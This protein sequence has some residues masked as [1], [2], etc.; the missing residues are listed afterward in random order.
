MSDSR[1]CEGC[2]YHSSITDECAE[3]PKCMRD[4]DKA[5]Y[6]SYIEGKKQCREE[7]ARE[8]ADKL[9]DK[10]KENYEHKDL[11][12]ECKKCMIWR[13]EEILETLAEWQKGKESETN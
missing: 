10:C 3:E 5:K 4:V 11:A 7:G 2:I 9:I 6:T 8:F 12:L 13:K 1:S